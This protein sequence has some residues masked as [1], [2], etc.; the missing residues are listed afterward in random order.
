MYTFVLFKRID[1]SSIKTRVYIVS[2]IIKIK[3]SAQLF[4]LRPS[5][6]SNENQLIFEVGSLKLIFHIIVTR[7]KCKVTQHFCTMRVQCPVFQ[8]H[9]YIL[10]G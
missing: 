8:D 5:K 6:K 3:F 2:M 7:G 1:L 10:P 9:F 4:G